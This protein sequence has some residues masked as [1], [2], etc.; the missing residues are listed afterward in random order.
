ML[1]IPVT[2]NTHTGNVNIGFQE[3][4]S[5]SFRIVNVIISMHGGSSLFEDVDGSG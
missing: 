1:E 2:L 5:T 3:R 4:L